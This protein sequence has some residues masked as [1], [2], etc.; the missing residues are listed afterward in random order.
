MILI[1]CWGDLGN[2]IQKSSMMSLRK[3]ILL[4]RMRRYSHL[5]HCLLD[6]LKGES[7]AEEKDQP[8]KDMRKSENKVS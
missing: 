6:K 2:L 1:Y 8:F 3:C 7:E 4:K 5:Y